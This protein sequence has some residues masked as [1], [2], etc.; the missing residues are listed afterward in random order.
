MK[1][2]LMDILACPYDK[3]F[4]LELYELSRTRY[5]EREVKIKEKPLCELYCAREGK[6]IEELDREPD[7]VECL[8]EEIVDGV[9]YC[10]KCGR[11]YPIIEEIPILLPDHLRNKEEDLAFLR[12]Y[13]DRLPDKITRE[14][15]PFS[16]EE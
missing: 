13:A 15:K 11:W 8:K 12:K 10:P 4:P 5:P 6:R 16:L 7:C 14:G 3:H 9:L 2:R 1:L